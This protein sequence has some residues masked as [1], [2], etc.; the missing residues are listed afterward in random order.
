MRSWSLPLFNG[1]DKII[2]NFRFLNL[3]FKLSDRAC[4]LMVEHYI[5]TPL[6]IQGPIV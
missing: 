4:G 3:A 5:F 2:S 1:F 6:E